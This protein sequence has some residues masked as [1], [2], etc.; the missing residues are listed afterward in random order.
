MSGF[1]SILFDR[2][3]YS[4]EKSKLHSCVYKDLNL[5]QIIST[6]ISSKKEYELD[7]FFYTPLKDIELIFYRQEVMKDLEKKS[8][9]KAIKEFELNFRMV[10]ESLENSNKLNHSY[11]KSSWFLQ[12][13]LLYC[14]GLKNLFEK[15]SLTT[16]NSKGLQLFYQYLEE[17]LNSEPFLNLFSTSQT[18]D[19][20]IQDI[21]YCLKIKGSC[22]KVESYK[23]QINYEKEIEIFFQ[24]FTKNSKD[25]Y[26]VT[27]GDYIDLNHVEEKVV[28]MLS[29]LYND[30]FLG[31]ENFYKN[32]NNFIDLKIKTFDREIQFYI[33]FLE[34]IQIM[35]K[36]KLSFCY[37]AVSTKKKD[38]YAS[39]LFDMTLAS[40]LSPQDFPIVCND[41]YLKDKERIIVVTG[42]NQGGKTTFARSIGEFFYFSSLGC[43][44]PAKKAEVFLQDKIFTHFEKEEDI[45]NLRSKLEDDIMRAKDILDEATSNSMVVVNE[46]F[47][48]TTLED[49][50]K[51]SENIIKKIIDFDLICIWVTFIDDISRFDEKI[52]SM[53]S[54]VDM[55][56]H[57]HK[58]YKIIREFA[59]GKAY[60][61]AIAKKYA[62]TYDD[63]TGRIK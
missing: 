22:I 9:F 53:V 60:A 15:L 49:A 33:S 2:Y 51:L 46:I 47:T 20:K 50:T 27:F 38:V 5:D 34:H 24:R 23:T 36:S 35:K 42:P 14:K 32:N 16:L 29:K 44:V 1:K 19:K 26:I 55:Q 63:I 45:K 30:E 10:R 56:N 52:V 31:L 39:C 61:K 48:S 62:L 17:Y 41:F 40:K 43:K 12:A 7:S 18:L 59:D 3:K 21:Q 57:E 28:Q 4:E 25:S 8:I 13:V 54:Q 6:I 58:T 37:P 11:Q